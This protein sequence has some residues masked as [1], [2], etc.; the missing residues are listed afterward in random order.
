MNKA[1]FILGELN[2]DDLNWMIRTG[3]GQT[4]YPG[5]ILIYEGKA[6]D[7]LYILLSGTLSVFI[8]SLDNKELAT[9]SSGEI[10]GEIS[11]LDTRSPVAT[12][13]AIEESLVL[14]IPRLQLTAK[15][16]QDMGF[17]SRFYHGISL[18]LSDRLRGTVRR[19]G[20]GQ[21]LNEVDIEQQEPNPSVREHLELAQA[22]FNWL[23]NSVKLNS[24]KEL[25]RENLKI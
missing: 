7:A 14:V 1:L 5:T 18:C 20:Y 8:E 23:M 9:I 17:A 15:L 2:N 6:I 11:F 25:Q 21:D 16:Q 10:V 22:K 13:K 12:V 3:R 19:L 4:L 24:A